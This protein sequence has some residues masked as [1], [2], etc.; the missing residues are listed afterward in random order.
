MKIAQAGGFSSVEEFKSVEELKSDSI[1]FY[2]QPY[3]KWK[4][5]LNVIQLKKEKEEE[6]INKALV[7]EL[8]TIRRLDQEYRQQIK[9]YEAKFGWNSKEVNEFWVKIDRQDSINLQ[10]V[11]RIIK[12]SGWPKSL[13]LGKRGGETIFLVVQHSNSE[14]QQK[15]LP[16]LKEAF[17]KGEILGGNLAM[18]EDRLA[19]AKGEPQIYGTQ[20]GRNK[21]TGEYFIP[22]ILNPEK[23][24]ERRK[25]R[26]LDAIEEYLKI[27]GLEWEN[28]KK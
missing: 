9:D 27:W 14:I 10:K 20:V 3:E 13:P 23:I 6:G 4:N 17:K 8:D 18:L 12:H 19:I 25:E 16:T 24:N 2:L 5:L 1:F 11:E 21:E 26:G 28:R 22:P 15:Y 7:M